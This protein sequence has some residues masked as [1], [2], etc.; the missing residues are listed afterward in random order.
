MRAGNH[1]GSAGCTLPLPTPTQPVG[2]GRRRPQEPAWALRKGLLVPG[3]RGNSDQWEEEKILAGQPAAVPSTARLKEAAGRE[4]LTPGILR[5]PGRAHPP[6]P[7][8]PA[9][10]GGPSGRHGR[11]R[12]PVT[13][14]QLTPP[15]H[16]LAQKGRDL[17][18]GP[19]E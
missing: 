4:A 16:S 10:K 1:Q 17:P 15:P 2:R 13:P 9:K 12:L 18:K 14:S 7:G 3:T 19:Q 11:K 8:R 5:G 6:H